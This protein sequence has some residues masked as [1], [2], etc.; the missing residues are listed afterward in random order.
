M[1]NEVS[2]Y[3]QRVSPEMNDRLDQLEAA[4][5]SIPQSR[6]PVNHLF[7]PGIYM[8]Q[9]FMA[10]GKYIMSYIHRT[11]HPYIITQGIAWVKVNDNKWNKL[12]AP[13]YGVTKAGTRRVLYIENDCV[14]TT[15][16]ATDKTNVEDIAEDI[17]EKHENKYINE[18]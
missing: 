17:L 13:Y 10:A 16:H 6:C 9:I 7:T 8:R 4:M 2:I 12:E 11:D 1:V 15:I 18:K 14:W 3:E 5:L